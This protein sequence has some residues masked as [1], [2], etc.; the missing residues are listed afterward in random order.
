M[1]KRKRKLTKKAVEKKKTTLL[2]RNK[3]PKRKLLRNRKKMRM[4][5]NLKEMIGKMLSSLALT[6][7]PRRKLRITLNKSR[8]MTLRKRP[9]FRLA[10]LLD[11]KTLRLPKRRR[12]RQ[13]KLM[14]VLVIC[15]QKPVLVPNNKLK[16]ERVRLPD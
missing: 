4:K 7:L 16:E 10:P 13:L 2:I 8:V 12:K 11:R 14:K 6:R 1:L 9:K 5:K 15:S 3:K